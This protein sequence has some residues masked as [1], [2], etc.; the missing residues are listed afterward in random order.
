MGVY[1]CLYQ[2]ELGLHQQAL[3][4]LQ[5]ACQQLLGQQVGDPFSQGVIDLEEEP[6]LGLIE[7]DGADHPSSPCRITST[8]PSWHWGDAATIGLAVAIG[9]QHLVLGDGLQGDRRGDGG[10]RLVVIFPVPMKARILSVS[11]MAT[12]PTP[13]SS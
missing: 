4:L 5:A 1:L 11:V 7:F 2:L 3:L 10:A 8:E 12:A 9:E 13:V 6:L